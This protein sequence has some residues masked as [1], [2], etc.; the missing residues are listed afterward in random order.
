MVT[1][2]DRDFFRNQ[3]LRLENARNTAD[4]ETYHR[5]YNDMLVRAN[6]LVARQSWWEIWAK[7]EAF[8]ILRD[9]FA[10]PPYLGRPTHAQMAQDMA[11]HNDIARTL[12]E[13]T[14]SLERTELVLEIV[15]DAGDAAQLSLQVIGVGTA[16]LAAKQLIMKVG[17][18]KAAELL[19]EGFV[20]SQIKAELQDKAID[21]LADTL[22]LDKNTAHQIADL[23]GFIKELKGKRIQKK[24]ATEVNGSKPRAS[25]AAP[26]PQAAKPGVTALNHAVVD[27]QEEQKWRRHQLM[28]K[29]LSLS[30]TARP[31]FRTSTKKALGAL[32]AGQERRHFAPWAYMRDM[33]AAAVTDENWKRLA[34]RLGYDATKFRNMYE[35]GVKWQRDL[36]N[37]HNNV[38]KGAGANN[39]RGSQQGETRFDWAVWNEK[40]Q[41]ILDNVIT[42]ENWKRLA[43]RAGYDP[44]K[45]S[46]VHAFKESW[47]K[48]WVNMQSVKY[49][50]PP[51]AWHGPNPAQ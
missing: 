44:A 15:K 17:V 33:V 40:R 20:E 25:N 10:I 49:A 1:Q 39:P 3:K 11:A 16:A 30:E 42:D 45:F 28:A 22:K 36:F 23:A 19:A 13:Q 21:V 5:I 43:G 51:V 32:Q 4:V 34:Q 48:D 26:S 47:R 8:A 14:E 46:D 6:K 24:A 27:L 38:W 35:F 2:T 7:E 37:E 41:G 31:L 29:P 18:K 50:V 9:V 12:Q